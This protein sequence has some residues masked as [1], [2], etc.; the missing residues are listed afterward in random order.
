MLDDI[1]AALL[2]LLTLGVVIVAWAFLDLWLHGL[3][4]GT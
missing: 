4:I 3:R 2:A 1:V